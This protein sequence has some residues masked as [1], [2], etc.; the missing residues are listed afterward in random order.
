MT[1]GDN[2]PRRLKLQDLHTLAK[3]VEAGSMRKAAAALN[4]TQPSVSRAIADLEHVVGAPLL[5][6]FRTGIE[7]TAYGRALLDGSNVIFD[8]LSQTVRRIE[9]LA[10]PEAGVVRIGCG[11]HLAASFVTA[12]ADRVA[13]RHPRISFQVIS[14]ERTEQMYTNL[15]NRDVDVLIARSWTSDGREFDFQPL[16][17]DDHHVVA[18]EKHPWSRRRSI[19]TNELSHAAW[20]LPP[21]ESPPGAIVAKAFAEA[22]LKYPHVT[23]TAVLPEARIGLLA[24]GRYLTV[25]PTSALDFPHKRPGLK[26]LPVNVR[27]ESIP[28]G[29]VT[30]AGRSQSP[31]TRLFNTHAQD[32]ANVL[33]RSARQSRA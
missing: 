24:T 26:I 10:D 13:C 5:E 17:D 21:K 27:F 23:L 7:P 6:R 9:A 19:S 30:L 8:E 1:S 22:G 2:L 12:V 33:R 3:V 29:I 18:G 20:V 31:A 4:T 32:V 25:F 11:Y 28:I 15:H 16:F 14:S